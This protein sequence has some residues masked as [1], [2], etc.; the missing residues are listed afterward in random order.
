MT[1]LN[2]RVDENLKKKAQATLKRQ[3]LDVST[4]VRMFLSQV[5]LEKG[6]PFQPTQDLAKLRAKW[7]K[8]GEEAIKYGK[9]YDSAEEMF[10][11][12]LKSEKKD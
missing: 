2:V 7:D 5:V 9:G 12:I 10:A 3:G 8:E 11:D 1:T 4:A 6:I